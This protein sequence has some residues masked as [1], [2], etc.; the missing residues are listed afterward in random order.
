MKIVVCLGKRILGRE[1]D[2]ELFSRVKK[3]VEIWKKY[4]CDYIIFSGGHTGGDK[5]EAEAMKSIA[6]DLKVPEDAIIL[7]DKSKNTVENA[8]YVKK[9]IER[10]EPDIIYVVTSPYHLPR[11]KIVFERVLKRHTM[12]FIPSS[13]P[14]DFE[15]LL[16]HFTKETLKLVRIVLFGLYIREDKDDTKKSSDKKDGE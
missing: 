2:L 7:E 11:T 16:S 3:A 9:I 13:Y 14:Y 8:L 12:Y 15:K 6:L 5:S 1:G 10:M 4:E